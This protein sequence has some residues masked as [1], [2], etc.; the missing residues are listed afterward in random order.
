MKIMWT[1][2]QHVHNLQPN[3][4]FV[5]KEKNT[6]NAKKFVFIK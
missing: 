5:I 3:K 1:I 2:K 6:N 4:W